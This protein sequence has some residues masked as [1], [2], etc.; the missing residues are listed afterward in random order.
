MIEHMIL[1][2]MAF[3]IVILSITVG[4]IYDSKRKLNKNINQITE[5]LS[6]ILDENT[7][8]KIMVFTEDKLL[9]QL[10][11]QINRMLEDR[12]RRKANYKKMELDSKR[13]LSNISHDIKTPL[14]VILGYLEI[15]ILNANDDAV[16]LKKVE[17]K[18]KQVVQLIGKFFTL[19]KIE[20]GDMDLTISHVQINEICKRNI[21]EYYD[22]LTDKEFTVEVQ[23]PDSD[24]YVY[25]NEDALD[26]IIYNLVSNV[27][28]YGYEGKYLCL[29]LYDDEQY[30]FIDM[31][32]RGKGIVKSDVANVFNRLYTADDSRNNGNG[33]G[34]TIV[35]S[36]VE[37]LGGEILLESE[38]YVKTVFTLKLRKVSY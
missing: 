30:V 10:I 14:T 22:I 34:L 38:P 7:D 31:I 11:T 20:A 32:D 27:I 1:Y 33:L 13:M 17:M 35:K 18:A 4:L 3:G 9:M 26:R 28:R 6:K 24:L 8:E 2:M 5:K 37:K 19:S 12:Q 25:G 21:I 15:M 36:L 23:I 29:K 16:M